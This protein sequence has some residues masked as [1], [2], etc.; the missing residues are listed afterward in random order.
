MT[1]LAISQST[2]EQ[3]WLAQ[4]WSSNSK[5][6]IW[7]MMPVRY[8]VRPQ[9]WRN[10][11]RTSVTHRR[12][13]SKTVQKVHPIPILNLR[14]TRLHCLPAHRHCECS[15]CLFSKLSK[16]AKFFKISLKL[17]WLQC[18][19][20]ILASRQPSVCKMGARAESGSGFR[21]CRTTRP[22]SLLKFH[23]TSLDNTICN[24]G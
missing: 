5:R 6:P 11:S 1:Q 17:R 8:S 16:M 21:T 22:S 3:I 13:R 4:S 10:Y 12:V 14:C 20:L 15:N 23:T 18:L 2:K 24:S 9:L 7:R 19:S